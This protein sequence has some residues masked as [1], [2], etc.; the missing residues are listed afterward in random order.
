MITD[1]ADG[2][3]MDARFLPLDLQTSSVHM[4]ATA[5]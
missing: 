3:S 4:A 2:L 1:E 5:A